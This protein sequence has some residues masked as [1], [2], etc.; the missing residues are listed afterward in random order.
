MMSDN[1]A[2]IVGID[3]TAAIDSSRYADPIKKY[4]AWVEQVKPQNTGINNTETE[5]YRF[6][7]ATP[8]GLLVLVTSWSGDGTGVFY[9]LHIVDAA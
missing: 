7:G 1:R 2:V 8:N 3:V 5:S 9:T 4:G 6:V